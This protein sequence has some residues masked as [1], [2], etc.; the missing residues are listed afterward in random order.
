MQAFGKSQS[1]RRIEDIRFLTGG[2]R[3]VDDI[4]PADA[5]HAVFFRASMAH[6]AITRLEVEAARA[7]TGVH[8]VLTAADLEAAGVRLG[9]QGTTVQ[10]RDGSR[11]AAPQRPV[12]AKD[13][14]RFVG[15][16]VALVV[17]D[18]LAL[19]RDAAELIDLQ[20]DALDA[21]VETAPGGPA[22]HPDVAPDNIAYDWALGDEAGVEAAFG[23][24][25]HRV[26]LRVR[27]NRIIANS[28]E[29][30][31]AYAEWDGAR[32]HLCVNGQGV[33]NQKRQLAVALGLPEDD[34]RVTNP[35]VGGGFGMKAMA[36][37]EYVAIAPPP[38]R[39]AARC[40][41]CPTGPRRC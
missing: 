14:V 25:A 33:W 9:M 30:R 29:P 20:C 18:S 4:A 1:I 8:L 26:G 2:G 36:Y 3:Y 15:E 28:M 11:G 39:W 24:A 40:A 27:H 23:A 19:A 13:H 37:P 10:N 6:G 35:D 7:A 21:H 16:A 32:L 34:V 22:V 5:L 17:A 38:V 41:G 31:G 12:L